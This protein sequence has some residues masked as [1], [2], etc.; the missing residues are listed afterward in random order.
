MD[1]RNIAETLEMLSRQLS[2]A[3][4]LSS[5][6]PSVVQ[7]LSSSAE[8]SFSPKSVLV[9]VTHG[10]DLSGIAEVAAIK[11]TPSTGMVSLLETSCLPNI[12][13]RRYLWEYEKQ[14]EYTTCIPG[15]I[16]DRHGIDE[17]DIIKKV[18]KFILE[19]SDDLSVIYHNDNPLHPP[20]IFLDDDISK[21][22]C[23]LYNLPPW[24]ERIHTTQ[25]KAG[26]IVK[27]T[28]YCGVWHK[29]SFNSGGK[30]AVITEL[31]KSC[32]G[33]RCALAHATEI[34]LHVK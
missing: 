2:T 6:A 30:S 25:C 1:L 16:R 5:P 18:R 23:T 3:V 24:V 29:L 33:H 10:D 27:Q 15:Y 17:A 11:D 22:T 26:L 20:S 13:S 8:A 32:Y 7:T 12:T 21:F 9:L 14:Q 4:N 34:Y 28:S 19:D 31:A